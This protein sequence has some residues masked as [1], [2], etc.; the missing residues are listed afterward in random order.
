MS[1]CKF[2][3]QI[4]PVQTNPFKLCKIKRKKFISGYPVTISYILIIARNQH[5]PYYIIVERI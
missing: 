5:G 1:L 3:K 4:Q 2:P